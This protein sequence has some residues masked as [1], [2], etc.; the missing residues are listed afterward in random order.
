MGGAPGSVW[1]HLSGM[2]GDVAALGGGWPAGFENKALPI[3]KV[4]GFYHVG[5]WLKFHSPGS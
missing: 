3:S 4:P 1:G 5:P 2:P